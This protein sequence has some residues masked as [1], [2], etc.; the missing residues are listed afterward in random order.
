VVADPVAVA[1]DIVL[2]PVP[3]PRPR[4]ILAASAASLLVA[5]FAGPAA[6]ESSF[7]G[8]EV[9]ASAFAWRPL[10]D[11]S[12]SW[13]HGAELAWG[14]TTAVDQ[15]AFRFTGILQFD[16][17]E[18]DSSS[19][20]VGISTHAFEAAA[21]L[22]AIEPQVR[23]GFALLTVDDFDGQLSAELLSPRAGAGLGVR[24]W[25]VRVSADVYAEYFWRW[26][27]PS[28]LVR[29]LSLDVRYE[30]RL[31]PPLPRQ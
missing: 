28:A 29:G 13:R 20:A 9:T 22:G 1:I 8:A 16:V 23:A 12:P 21:R 26:F 6:A 30:R 14:P 27:G 24:F 15:G 2:A 18:F 19:W 4:A 31:P 5:T 17:R 11:A 3:G 25:K 10:H 7:G